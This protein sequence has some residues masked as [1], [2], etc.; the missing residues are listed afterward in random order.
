MVAPDGC[1]GAVLI[2]M[3]TQK[4]V[5]GENHSVPIWEVRWYQRA[6]TNG[7][8]EGYDKAVSRDTT[9]IEDSR[10]RFADQRQ[11]KDVDPHGPGE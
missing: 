6:D 5:F 9:S 10:D 1:A 4:L 11:A 2:P 8:S 3:E 7:K